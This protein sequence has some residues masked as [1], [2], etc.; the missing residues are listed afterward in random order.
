MDKHMILYRGSL[1][2]CNYHCSYCPFSKHPMSARELERDRKQ[3]FSFVDGLRKKAGSLNVGALMVVPYGEA[4]IHSWYWEGLAQLS[5]RT[6]LDAVGIQ[7]NLS[8]PIHDFLD[9][10]LRAGGALDKLRLWATFHPEMTTVSEFSARCRALW[11]KGVLLCAGSVGVPENLEVLQELKRALA[12]ET[13]IYLWVNRMDGLRRPYTQKE[14][15]AFVEIDPYFGRELVPVAADAAQCRG[16]LFVEAD[17]TLR[18]CNISAVS[19]VHKDW[20]TLE[21]IPE[22][23]CSRR[24]CSCYLAHGGRADFMNQIL[25]GPYPL[26]RIPRRPKAVFLDIV[27]TLLP[28]GSLAGGSTARK[29]DVPA[30]IAAGLEA[31][32]EEKIPLFF[33]TTLP[34]REAMARCHSVRHLFSGGIFAG[35]A[36]LVTRRPFSEREYFCE[37]DDAWLADLTAREK[38]SGFRVLTYR[39][40]GKLYKVSLLRPAHRPWTLQEAK[41]LMC[42]I[43]F[44]GE[45]VRYYIEGSCLQVVAATACKA[46]GVKTICRWLGISPGDAAAAGDSQE[47]AKMLS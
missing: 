46:Q 40:Q 47:D 15:A 30:D 25:F 31:L 14:R 36:H 33:A 6:E 7:T 5:A 43:P 9:C 19:K 4:M 2:S 39:N 3:W 27:G 32:A 10:Y 12:F 35:G 34:Y 22:P 28:A 16:R 21:T 13:D 42:S 29:A 11:E 41:M 20:E 44:S 45:K 24:Q 26:F 23:E 37:L 8:F 1:K 38:A 18:A 17:K